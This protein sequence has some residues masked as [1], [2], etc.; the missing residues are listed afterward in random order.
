MDCS[1]PGSSVHGILQARLLE[2]VALPSS[3][4]SSWPRDSTHVSCVSCI[5]RRILYH[6]SPKVA[7]RNLWIQSYH[8][9]QWL[10]L[11]GTIPFLFCEKENG[12]KAHKYLAIQ[13]RRNKDL[14]TAEN[15][16]SSSFHHFLFELGEVV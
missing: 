8:S 7:L 12:G 16:V 4:G 15:L 2:W 1:L 9:N 3:R 10:M 11:K 14:K 6:K 5:G 13:R